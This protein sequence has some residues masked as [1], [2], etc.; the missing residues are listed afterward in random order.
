MMV[1]LIPGNMREQGFPILG[2]FN[3]PG[4]LIVFGIGYP[5]LAAHLANYTVFWIISLSTDFICLGFFFFF[6]PESMPDKMKKPVDAWDFFPMTCVL[7]LQGCRSSAALSHT[8]TSHACCRRTLQIVRH[9][10]AQV[11]LERYED[12]L[13]VPAAHRHRSFDRD[14]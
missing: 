3:I 10:C 4:Q 12:C 2:L 14:Q 8:A 9:T 1:D 11:L 7:V 6:L 5:L 13:Q